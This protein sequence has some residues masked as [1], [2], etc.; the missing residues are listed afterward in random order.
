MNWCMNDFNLV[1]SSAKDNRTIVTN[2]KT[3]SVVMEFPTEQSLSSIKWSNKMPGKLAGTSI[4]GDTSVLSFSKVQ[5]QDTDNKENTNDNASKCA[6]T[7]YAPKW[8]FPKCG[9]RFGFGGKLISFNGKTLKQK[10]KVVEPSESHMG[11]LVES[12]DK[13]LQ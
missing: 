9:A 11:K 5:T 4:E 7:T 13:E 10:T 1:A 3:G 12:F 6:P 2:F 8:L